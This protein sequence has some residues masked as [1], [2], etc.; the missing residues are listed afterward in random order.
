MRSNGFVART[1]SRLE[2]NGEPFRF[3]G[4]NVYWLGL[5]ENVEGVAW[6][7]EFRV[8]DA[9]DTALEMGATVVRS[10]TLGASQGH[11][12]SIMP[13]P[14]RFNEEALRRVDFAVREAAARGLRL[15]VPFVCNWS[16]YHGGRSTFAGWRGLEDPRAFYSDPE[17]KEVFKRYIA[18][19]LTR[20]NALTGVAYRDDPTILAWELGNELNDAPAEWVKEMAAYIKSL[21]GNHLVAHGKQFEL[22]RDKLG[23]EELDI[24]DVHYYPANAEALARDAAETAAAGKVYICGEFGW[25]ED[26]LEAFLERAEADGSVSGTLFWSLFPHADDAGYVP[27]YDGFSLHYP[28]TGVSGDYERRCLELRSHAFRMSGREVSS[29]LVPDAPTVSSAA[30]RVVFRGVVGAARYTVEKSTR[31]AAGPWTAVFDAR[32]AD[33]DMPWQ[34]PTRAHGTRTWYRVQAIAP[35]GAAGPWSEPFESEPFTPVS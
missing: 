12:L 20:V 21:D 16:Y 19:L 25:T 18:M 13:E 23:I 2:L 5:D 34:D 11:P 30:E 31:G 29:C 32:P 17:I 22:D 33:H 27:H 28:G 6:P 3:A 24:L 15:I 7:T 1:G 9:L 10:H 8:R 26:G 4:P 14:D 35:D